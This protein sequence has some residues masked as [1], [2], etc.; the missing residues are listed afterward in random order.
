MCVA[1][2]E[3][4][5]KIE[6]QLKHLNQLNRTI[7]RMMKIRQTCRVTTTSWCVLVRRHPAHNACHRLVHLR[8]KRLVVPAVPFSSVMGRVSPF[9]KHRCHSGHIPAHAPHKNE[10]S[11]SKCNTLRHNLGIPAKPPS[12]SSELWTSGA[13]LITFTWIG[14]RPDCIAHRVGEQNYTDVFE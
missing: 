10:K 1:A 12:G 7:I 14:A 3:L 9:G 4:K 11:V 6:L 8:T 5:D 2:S 13:A